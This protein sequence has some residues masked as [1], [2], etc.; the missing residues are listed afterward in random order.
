FVPKESDIDTTGLDIKP[1]TMKALLA[2]DTKEWEV[3]CDGVEEFFKS[4]GP[5]VPKEMFSQLEALR[6]RLKK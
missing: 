4:L 2:I 1:E 6:A 3:E 5:R